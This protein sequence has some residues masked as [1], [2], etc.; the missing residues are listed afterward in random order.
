[1]RIPSSSMRQS[2]RA[3]KSVETTPRA[4]FCS[5]L[6]LLLLLLIAKLLVSMTSI[7]RW[8][9]N[10]SYDHMYRVESVRSG[11]DDVTDQVV[12]VDVYGKTFMVPGVQG[13]SESWQSEGY[14]SR[15][16]LEQ[17]LNE[18]ATDEPAVVVFDVDTSPDVT[19]DGKYLWPP[20]TV[21]LLES[22][23]R[24]RSGNPRVVSYFGVRRTAMMP[25][26]NWLVFP[27]YSNLAVGMS[28]LAEGSTDYLGATRVSVPGRAG[29]TL[30]QI[31]TVAASEYRIKNYR[32]PR[33]LPAF[34]RRL[35]DLNGEDRSEE[36]Y[37]ITH[38]TF[39]VNYDSYRRLYDQ[40]IVITN[41]QQLLQRPDLRDRLR[42]KVVIIGNATV[43]HT[44]DLIYVDSLHCLVPGVFVH[45]CAAETLISS[46][47]YRVNYWGGLVVSASL[48]FA[49]LVV[50][51][52]IQYA[53]DNLKRKG[54]L[55]ISSSSKIE[56]FHLM[57]TML[58]ISVL[59]ILCVWASNVYG[60]IAADLY[61]VVIFLLLEAVL[62]TRLPA[63]FREYVREMVG[64]LLKLLVTAK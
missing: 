31:A 53:F 39:P 54:K 5:G 44:R 14:T 3:T 34:V 20:D 42:N 9:D 15:Q 27:R 1:M 18:I 12:V 26:D 28:L 16:A 36:Q 22:A 57:S 38:L 51:S 50:I 61:L 33:T 25:R 35:I 7:G 37:G 64:K 17:T 13:S 29:T 40:R 48:S 24:W 11:V 52:V 46:P 23:I 19:P 60:I 55:P 56:S 30:P 41:P 4:R 62:T 21:S 32:R 59:I 8:L 43:E 10:I 2:S 49:A 63:D 6:V 47:I 58:L 45:A